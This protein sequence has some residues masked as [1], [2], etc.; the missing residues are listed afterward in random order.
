MII[1]KLT[2]GFDRGTATNQAADLGLSTA[3]KETDAGLIVRGLGTH[4][5]S[6]SAREEAKERANEE[7]RIRAAFKRAFIGSPI[8]GTYVLPSE[9]AGTRLLSELD[10]PVRAD[11]NARIA[12]YVLE[13]TVLPPAEVSEWADRIQKQLSALPFGRGQGRDW[14]GTQ[15]GLSGLK[16]LEGLA[17]CPVI[18][19]ETRDELLQLIADS[20][21]QKLDR[22][23]LKRKLAQVQV[24]V[25]ASPVAPRRAP[26]PVEKAPTLDTPAPTIR[27]RRR[28]K[29][30]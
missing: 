18:G 5:R 20:K 2:I 23:Q 15:G 14:A 12:E 28:R 4:Y 10:P 27:P 29:V 11:V 16:L 25:E 24:E 17:K 1:G 6:A 3:P 7:G 13:P 21:L 30:S 8:P 26:A 9:G 22:V 19:D